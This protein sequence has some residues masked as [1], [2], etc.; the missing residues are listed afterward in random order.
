[1]GVANATILNSRLGHM[2][3]NAIGCGTFRVEDT[4]IRGP[5]IFNL[6]DD[7]GS[8]WEGD[9]IVKNCKPVRLSPNTYMF[10]NVKVVR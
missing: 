3:I 8:T 1:M 4:E 5:G 10:R 9:F 6:R 2:G 7:Y